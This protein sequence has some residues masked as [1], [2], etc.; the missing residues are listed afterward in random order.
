MRKKSK[1][2]SDDSF[3]SCPN[4]DCLWNDEKNIPDGGKWYLKH[5]YY[6]SQQH[7]K[8]ARFICRNCRKTFSVRTNDENC[9]LHF[10]SY[11]VREIGSSYY[12][13]TPQ[14][15]IAHKLG[16]SAQMVRTR[17]RRYNP[18]HEGLFQD[19]EP[20]FDPADQNSRERKKE[21]SK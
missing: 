1:D 21:K 20:V 6:T 10:D 13:G 17:L 4:P 9:Y 19:W 15:T 8:V 14:K 5:G 7:G 12:G 11:D 16:I 2:G 3:R 18:F